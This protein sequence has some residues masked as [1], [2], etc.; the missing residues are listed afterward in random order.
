MRVLFLVVGLLRIPYRVSG[1]LDSDV[2]SFLLL[3][4]KASLSSIFRS[5]VSLIQ[6]SGVQLHSEACLREASALP[7]QALRNSFVA[8]AVAHGRASCFV[9]RVLVRRRTAEGLHNV[10]GERERL[11]SDLS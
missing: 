4:D 9:P 7:P 2:F 11:K 1:S 5:S 10:D 6:K 3:H 8:G